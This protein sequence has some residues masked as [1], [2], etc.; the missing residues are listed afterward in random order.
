MNSNASLT[1]LLQRPVL[2]FFNCLVG[3]IRRSEE[4]IFVFFLGYFEQDLGGV[5]R[6]FSGVH[7]YHDLLIPG[8]FLPGQIIANIIVNVPFVPSDP[9]FDILRHILDPV[10]SLLQRHWSVR[11]IKIKHIFLIDLHEHCHI[12]II[13]CGCGHSDQTDCGL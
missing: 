4:M 7:E 13:W 2:Q 12:Y 6:L 10:E 1:N 3:R 11:R 8:E 9:A 5:E